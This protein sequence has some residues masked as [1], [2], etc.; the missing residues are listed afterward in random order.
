[1]ELRP[2][3]PVRLAPPLMGSDGYLALVAAAL[4][5]AVGGTAQRP[6]LPL[7]VGGGAKYRP[8]SSM[9]HGNGSVTKGRV[10]D[11]GCWRDRGR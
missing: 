3:K 5:Q 9:G 6:R 11:S 4:A 1:M 7:R 10:V 8:G 2:L